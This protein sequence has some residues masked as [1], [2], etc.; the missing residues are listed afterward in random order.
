LGTART[1][2]T[3]EKLQETGMM[4]RRSGNDRPWTA[5]M[6]TTLTFLLFCSVIFIHKLDSLRKEYVIWFQMFSAAILPNIIKICR[7]LTE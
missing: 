4:A 1:E 5:R 7:H 2:Q 6:T 3:F